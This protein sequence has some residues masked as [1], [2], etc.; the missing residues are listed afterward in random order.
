ML[1][2]TV[3]F[4]NKTE[5]KVIQSNESK[6]V[7]Q[8]TFSEPYLQ[9]VKTPRGEAFVISADKAYPLLSTGNPDVPRVAESVLIPDL[10][11]MEITA[12]NID[13]Q[14]VENMEVPPSKGSIARDINPNDVPFTYGE[15]YQK[16]KFFPAKAASLDVP[17]ILND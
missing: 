16:N 1:L 10:G 3:T 13:A 2:S 7:L 6:I 8:V 4:A 15:S 12:I 14:I 11:S 5:V 17:Y 9:A